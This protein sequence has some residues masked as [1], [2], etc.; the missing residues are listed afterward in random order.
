MKKFL[1]LFLLLSVLANAQQ[2]NVTFEVV[3]ESFSEEDLITITASDFS[4]AV[5]G[6]TDVYLWAWAS[7]NGIQEDSPT[8]GEWKIRQN[9][10]WAVNYGSDGADGNLQAGGGNIPVT[11]GYY[12]VIVDFNKLT[13]SIEKTSVYGVVGS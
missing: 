8:N 12:E 1:L 10:D 7:A 11:L 5:W 3:P 13:Y 6:V 4:P 9:N 2:Q